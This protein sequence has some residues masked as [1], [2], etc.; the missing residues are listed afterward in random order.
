MQGMQD[1]KDGKQRVQDDKSVQDIQKN[2][3][4]MTTFETNPPHENP[5][6]VG[7]R[8]R[9]PPS[10][11]TSSTEQS[12]GGQ[13]R[14]I[15]T[16]ASPLPLPQVPEL[17]ESSSPI[18]TDKTLLKLQQ[19]SRRLSSFG[20]NVPGQSFLSIENHPEGQL[21]EPNPPPYSPPETGTPSSVEE[22]WWVSVEKK[23]SVLKKFSE[24]VDQKMVDHEKMIQESVEHILQRENEVLQKKFEK[25]ELDARNGFVIAMQ[26]LGQSQGSEALVQ[27]AREGLA[28]AAEA[29]GQSTLDT[30]NRMATMELQ[31]NKELENLKNSQKDQE[32]KFDEK[33]MTM[34]KRIGQLEKTIKDYD[35]KFI[36]FCM[37]FEIVKKTVFGTLDRHTMNFDGLTE[38]LDRMSEILP[39]LQK[40]N[41]LPIPLHDVQGSVPGGGVAMG[42]PSQPMQVDAEPRRGVAAGP[43]SNPSHVES[44]RGEA[45][46]PPPQVKPA[47]YPEPRRGEAARPPQQ[48]TT[49]DY[50]AGGRGMATGPP[51]QSKQEFVDPH[52]GYSATMAGRVQKLEKEGFW[53]VPSHPP[54]PEMHRHELSSPPVGVT[55][56]GKG[57]YHGQTY[58]LV[59]ELP[60]Y[61]LPPGVP[62]P[63]LSQV[64]PNLPLPVGLGFPTPT[65]TPVVTGAAV[66]T[67]T[68]TISAVGT[69]PN[70]PNP[71]NQ[72]TVPYY[73]IA[74]S[75]LASSHPPPEPFTGKRG[76]WGDF[77]RRWETHVGVLNA[78]GGG[79]PD[80]FLLSRLESCL[81]P[82]TKC[83][84]RSWSEAGVAYS[85]IWNRL[86]TY[87]E[88]DSE[89]TTRAAWESL[90]LKF[91]GKLSSAEWRQFAA[92]FTTLMRRCPGASEGEGL[93]LLR[94][95][96]PTFLAE[97][98]ELEKSKRGKSGGRTLG[99]SGLNVYAGEASAHTWVETV[100]GQ[101]PNKVH[102]ERDHFLVEPRHSTHR[103]S[104]L[105]LN[106]RRLQDGST[107]E[108]WV[109]DPPVDV[110]MA[111]KL[112]GDWIGMRESVE[113][114]KK[115]L[116]H[117]VKG[118]HWGSDARAVSTNP[119]AAQDPQ[120]LPRPRTPQQGTPRSPQ[121]YSP[122][123]STS[124]SYFGGRDGGKGKGKGGKNG[125]WKG[126]RG[127]ARPPTPQPNPQSQPQ[128]KPKAAEK[129]GSQGGGGPPPK[130]GH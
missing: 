91:Q 87:F 70:L 85:L 64:L 92:T 15:D 10:T 22:E 8:D 83:E 7:K 16:S 47:E 63:N 28:R 73:G 120:D 55:N 122:R 37:D 62:N 82:P 53:E 33:I 60:P 56:F 115:L 20:E 67:G 66:P 21:G 65:P 26:A 17:S 25:L 86:C 124:S 38:V 94:R 105:D 12:A 80:A 118:T 112:V 9:T 61:A 48:S 42:P 84:V 36:K 51:P 110:A 107:V 54:P 109:R 90:A 30:N 96:L 41:I 46:G 93:R 49:M 4:A 23:L 106:G 39:Q 18:P 27:F 99:V 74:N 127:P 2:D 58:S 79:V 125:K 19:I 31:F 44:R 50:A 57:G 69:L 100:T 6:G 72:V 45:T 111:I 78:V 3:D 129:G 116:P 81:D 113:E 75:F 98:L 104:I 76:D 114:A 117:K 24:E 13:Y 5:K 35:E 68:A 103:Q 126:G 29:L 43:P 95:Q 88:K 11:S 128:P 40:L 52:H 34:E 77:K 121:V 108:V 101:A 71:Q 32:K 123:N 59:P 97:K 102:R 14:K 89:E 1:L 119:P 130:S